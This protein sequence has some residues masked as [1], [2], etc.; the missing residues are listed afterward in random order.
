M[1]QNGMG[2]LDWSALPL[3]IEYFEIDDVD[4]LLFRLMT[5]KAYRPP[6]PDTAKD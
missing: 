1:M 6:E 4:D 5:I 2:G 3:A